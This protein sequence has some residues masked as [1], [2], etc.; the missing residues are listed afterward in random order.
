M[1]ELDRRLHASR[2]MLFRR[3]GWLCLWQNL[4]LMLTMARYGELYTPD[5]V[6]DCV[7]RSNYLSR[8]RRNYR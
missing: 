7:V 2:L 1:Q 6:I 4:S 5:T 3:T 8:L